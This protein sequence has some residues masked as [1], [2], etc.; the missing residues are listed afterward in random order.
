MALF[1]SPLARWA[2]ATTLFT[3]LLQVLTALRVA[4]T[5]ITLWWRVIWLPLF[6]ALDIAMAVTGFWG[7]LINLPQNW[8]E[9]RTRQ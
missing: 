5:P 8:E 6:L 9:R 7:K 3:P 2:V 1:G 4:H